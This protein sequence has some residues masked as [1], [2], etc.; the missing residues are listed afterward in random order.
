[1]PEAE[2]LLPEEIGASKP[3]LQLKVLETGTDF[4]ANQIF[5]GARMIVGR[6]ELYLWYANELTS[7]SNSSSEPLHK[8]QL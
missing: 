7:N 2:Q 6:V 4:D 1:M 8:P 5:R 3:I